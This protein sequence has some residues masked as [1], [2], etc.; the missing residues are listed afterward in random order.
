MCALNMVKFKRKI[1]SPPQTVFVSIQIMQ[2]ISPPFKINRNFIDDTEKVNIIL[3]F[4]II[5]QVIL[6][7]QMYTIIIKDVLQGWSCQ[8]RKLTTATV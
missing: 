1:V 8:K 7:W 6:F 2:S 3:F 5:T 4:A